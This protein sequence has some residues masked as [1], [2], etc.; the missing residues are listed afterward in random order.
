MLSVEPPVSDWTLEASAASERVKYIFPLLLTPM[1]NRFSDPVEVKSFRSLVKRYISEL[2]DFNKAQTC[3]EK[4]C[5]STSDGI[6]TV[7]SELP[8]KYTPLSLAGWPLGF[9]FVIVVSWLV[10]V[11]PALTIVVVGLSKARLK[12]NL[13]DSVPGSVQFGAP[14]L[15][16]LVGQLGTQY[17]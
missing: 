13:A 15:D 7:P 5:D 11:D 6:P 10:E 17:L 1:F 2:V 14:P 8:S 4:V 9:T 16:H 3:T 12:M